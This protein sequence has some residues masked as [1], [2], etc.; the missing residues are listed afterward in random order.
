MVNI[1][2]RTLDKQVERQ[3]IEQLGSLIIRSRAK[4]EVGDILY[5][6][7]TPTERTQLAKRLAIIVLLSNNTSSTDIEHALGVSYTTIG[8]YIECIER[9]EYEQLLRRV[10]ARKA[11]SSIRKL[12][13]N[14]GII[15]HPAP[16]KSRMRAAID[17]F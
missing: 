14:I 6:L 3:I 17:S 2:K 5:T 15:L 16:K 12:F 9:G 4:S 10:K 8:K 13:T 7:L 11:D 1:S